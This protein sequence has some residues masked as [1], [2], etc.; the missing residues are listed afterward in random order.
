[1][2]YKRTLRRAGLAELFRVQLIPSDVGHRHH[3]RE[4]VQ[5]LFGGTPV[6]RPGPQPLYGLARCDRRPGP[7]HRAQCGQYRARATSRSR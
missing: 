2:R 7:Q 4:P 6:G 1:M 5:K 3:R